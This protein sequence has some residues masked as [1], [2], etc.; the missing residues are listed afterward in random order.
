MRQLNRRMSP[1][2]STGALAITLLALSASPAVAGQIDLVVRD[3][4]MNTACQTIVTIAN[5][6][7]TALPTGTRIE[8]KIQRTQN[9]KGAGGYLMP[10]VL[11][12]PLAPQGQ[13]SS[14]GSVQLISGTMD[15]WADIDPNRQI[16]ES[17]ENN[18]RALRTFT[19]AGS[20]DLTA[21]IASV[22]PSPP[23]GT[24]I[25]LQVRVRNIGT[26]AMPWPTSLTARLYQVDQRGRRNRRST[27][28]TTAP[29]AVIE[30]GG[31]RLVNLQLQ[32][33]APGAGRYELQVEADPGDRVAETNERNNSDRTV[34]DVR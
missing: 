11:R 12:Q 7:D 4:T 18:N 33:K 16:V 25:T 20:A 8:V 5:M 6:G 34:V 21:E 14:G 31:Q 13:L 26:A 24:P 1:F 3:I 32:P 15:V 23:A 9:G 17:N 19:C 30:P 28:E 10:F 29:L 27:V 2:L 22:G